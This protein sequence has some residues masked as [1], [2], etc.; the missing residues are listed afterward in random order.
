MPVLLNQSLIDVLKQLAP[1]ERDGRAAEEHEPVEGS[2]T[3]EE[4]PFSNVT[5]L[6]AGAYL[7]CEALGDREGSAGCESEGG[8]EE[9]V[10]GELGSEGVEEVL[11]L[12]LEGILEAAEGAG[13]DGLEA[14][15]LVDSE[16]R[17]AGEDER[18][19]GFKRRLQVMVMDHLKI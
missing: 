3:G 6:Q 11:E 8:G 5:A 9:V 15:A 1:L 13:R 7:A 10:R 17:L 18:R 14:T 16:V 19:L 2:R 12:G 4:D